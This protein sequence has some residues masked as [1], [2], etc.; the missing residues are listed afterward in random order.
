MT[1]ALRQEIGIGLL[2]VGR[3][4]LR[5]LN[6][7]IS[8]V[9]GASVAAICRK[10]REE[11][12]DACLPGIPVYGEYGDL[13][14][15]PH[16]QAVVVVTVPSLCHDICLSAVRAGKP[17]LIEKP[18]AMTGNEARAMV[19]AAERAGVMLMTAQTMRFDPTIL[20]VKEQLPSLGLLQRARFTSHIEWNASLRTRIGTSA[21]LGAMLE[22]GVHLLD[23]VRFLTGEEVV[24]AACKMDRSARNHGETV[25]E[26]HLRTVSGT[27]CDLDVARIE[28]G[29][30]G[31]MEWVGTEG[32]MTADW[33]QRKVLRHLKG[34]GHC[35]WT[36]EPRPTIVTVLRSFV[37]AITTG[38]PPPVTGLDG[39]R[40]VELADA[41]YDSAEQGGIGIR[42]SL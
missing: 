25:A 11:R 34:E 31:T 23:L 5:Y 39:C 17:M 12:P 20:L 35:E 37:H 33:V 18:L 38:T 16:V 32:S 26:A 40:A 9:P 1:G 19:A 41:C 21:P 22:L 3:H 24:E 13:I 14:A 6:H 2:G 4:G 28:S 27:L 7:L 8:D 42:V 30:T 29:R 36:V 15:D 10:H